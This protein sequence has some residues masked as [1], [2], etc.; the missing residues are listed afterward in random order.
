M[1]SSLYQ[2]SWSLKHVKKK[3]TSAIFSFCVCDQLAETLPF[4][5]V[6]VDIGLVNVIISYKKYEN[7]EM[8]NGCLDHESQVLLEKKVFYVFHYMLGSVALFQCKCIIF[9][10]A[11]LKC[12]FGKYYN[13][14]FTYISHTGSEEAIL[15]GI[16]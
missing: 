7:V 1:V 9:C 6:L 13:V 2:Y 16:Y 10:N 5:P 11:S 15:T 3:A 8:L 4:V 12:A 14:I